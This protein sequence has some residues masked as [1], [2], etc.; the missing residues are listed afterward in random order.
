MRFPAE[1]SFWYWFERQI[2]AQTGIEPR[3]WHDTH[4]DWQ[5]QQRSGKA[6]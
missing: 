6:H 3:S 5:E 4:P 2:Q 1:T